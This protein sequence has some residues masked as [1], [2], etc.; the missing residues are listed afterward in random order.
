[1]NLIELNSIKF[2]FS[3]FSFKDFWKSIFFSLQTFD[4]GKSWF[5]FG[6]SF[7]CQLESLFWEEIS[8]LLEPGKKKQEISYLLSEKSSKSQEILHLL[9]NHLLPASYF[10]SITERFN[11]FK[12][13]Q[14]STSLDH[15]QDLHPFCHLCHLFQMALQ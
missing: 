14:V 15:R 3:F 10:F 11:L 13:I 2:I 8:N 9:L 5:S 6:T 1:M 12:D 7:T 4:I